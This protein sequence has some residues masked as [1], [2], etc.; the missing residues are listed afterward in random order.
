M[1]M[2]SFSVQPVGYFSCDSEFTYD[3]PRQ[4]SLAANRGRIILNPGLENAVFRLDSFSHIWVL[5]IFDRNS[6]WKPMVRPPRHTEQKV[7]VFASR[8][9]YRPSGIGLSC[10]RLLSVHG[11]VLDVADHDILDGSPVIDIK[12]YVPYADSFPDASPGWTALGDDEAF[13]LD[14]SP[15][16]GR[17]LDWLTLNGVPGIR[18]FIFDRLSTSPLDRRRNRLLPD[19][20]GMHVLAYRT[21]R[22]LFKVTPGLVSVA[23]I[24][25]GYKDDELK[26]EN[27]KY[28]DKAVHR[29][30]RILFPP[31]HD[32]L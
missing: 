19:K 20:G 23:E 2:Q 32:R 21:W 25:S 17:Q 15:E 14:F 3:V 29:Q 9:P 28:M 10:V 27:D 13:R 11:L 18:P 12:P 4:G 30:F 24:H 31:C 22:V 26:D 1:T 8:S 16:A 5:F 7:G 6:S